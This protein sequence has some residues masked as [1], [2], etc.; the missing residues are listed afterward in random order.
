M[1]SLLTDE[2][3]EHLHKL[4]DLSTTQESWVT[5][6]MIIK[7]CNGAKHLSIRHCAHTKIENHS[8]MFYY[9]VIKKAMIM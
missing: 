6:V 1:T 3:Y 8:Q 5:Q 9:S 4:E 2:F 7:T